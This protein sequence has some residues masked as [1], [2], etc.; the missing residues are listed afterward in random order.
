MRVNEMSIRIFEVICINNIIKLD[1]ILKI[2]EINERKFRYELDVFNEVLYENSFGSIN[3]KHGEIQY[4]LKKDVKEIHDYLNSIIR[5]G[6][7]DRL[8]YIY[9][10]FLVNNK[11]NLNQLSN[12]LDISKV[13]IRKDLYKLTLELDEGIDIKLCKQY[14]LIGEE[15]KIREKGLSIL[16]KSFLEDNVKN[17][18]KDNIFNEYREKSIEF[19]K[20]V[21][22]EANLNGRLYFI[23]LTY[24]MIVLIRIKQ[25]KVLTNLSLE[26]CLYLMEFEEYKKVEENISILSEN[27]KDNKYEILMLTDFIVGMTFKDTN[28]VTFNRWLELRIIVQNFIGN[29][30]IAMNIPFE[31]DNILIEDLI[32]HI[33]PSIYRMRSDVKLN[34][35]NYFYDEINTNNIIETIKKEIVYIEKIFEIE[36]SIEEIILFAVHFEASIERNN[37]RTKNYKKVLLM[38]AGGYGTTKILVHKLKNRYQIDEMKVASIMEMDKIKL[39][40]YD[41]LIT[42]IDIK[43]EKLNNFTNKIRISPFLTNKE[44]EILDKCFVL[45]NNNLNYDSL[46]LNINSNKN[47]DEPFKRYIIDEISKVKN[48][49]NNIKKY[50]VCNLKKYFN[51][52]NIFF[53]D[54]K[55]NSWQEVINYGVDKMEKLGFVDKDYAVDIIDNINKYGSYLVVSSNVAIPHAKSSKKDYKNGNV[56][57]FLKDKVV[58]PGNKD[59]KLLFFIYQKDNEQ[60]LGLIN[61]ILSIVDKKEVINNINNIDELN[62]YILI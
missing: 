57:L 5:I 2:L 9:L 25:G 28:R 61:K 12:E 31:K 40:E 1:N 39:D 14:Y 42:T 15:L 16:L 8:D 62:E 52:H 17:V 36:F 18:I 3:L 32:N 38:C 49:T 4:T 59:V 60:D 33:N 51:T 22:P 19:L 23:V 29:M 13:T 53:V 37:F 7:R 55:I 34:D 10:S 56:V 45:K 41:L 20:K 44:L 58:F 50:N 21:N 30:S 27:I 26:E 43:S 35:I 11:V 6:L 54:N 24:I 47:I 48:E 46:I